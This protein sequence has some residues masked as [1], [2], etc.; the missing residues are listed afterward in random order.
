MSLYYL[1]NQ[2]GGQ[3]ILGL[4]NRGH[5][6]ARCERHLGLQFQVLADGP[7]H[8]AVARSSAYR[9]RRRFDGEEPAYPLGT[10]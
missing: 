1:I 2:F 3:Y 5:D 8:C 4:V 6:P 10:L 7:A 9:I